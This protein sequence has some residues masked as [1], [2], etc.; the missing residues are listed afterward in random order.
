ML[1][2]PKSIS[3]SW[4]KVLTSEFEKPYFQKLQDFLVAE[5]QTQTIFPAAADVFSAF[6]LTPYE[7]VK[8]LVLGQDPY[9]DDNQAHGLCF[10]VNP[11]IKTPPSL[12]N[13]YKELRD[14]VGCKIPNNGYLVPW[15]EQGILMLNAVLTVRAHTPNSHKNQGWETFTDA[16]ISKVNQKSDPVV[17]ILWGAYA[18]KKLN[19]IDTSRHPVIQSAHPSP[20]S[21]RN[22]FF[23]SKPFSAINTA[24]NSCGQSEINWQIPD[25]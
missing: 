9:H 6:E 2:S 7:S 12:V 4:Q 8:V 5:R 3:S 20:L 24:L 19:L 10:S 18:Q 11:G 22:G 16:V 1:T 21:A 14:D 25:L 13:I 15:A 23:G 17:F